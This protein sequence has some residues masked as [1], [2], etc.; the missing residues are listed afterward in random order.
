MTTEPTEFAAV[1]RAFD[2]A[3]TDRASFVSYRE[4]PAYAGG[5]EEA[6]DA[7]ERLLDDGRASEVVEMSEHSLAA[8]E[9]AIEAVDDSDGM[10][11]DL[12]RRLQTLHLRAC[13][14][15]QPDPEH[16]AERLFAWEMGSDWETFLGAAETYAE[17]LGARGLA[18]YRVLAE[19]AWRDVPE[20]RPGDGGLGFGRHGYFRISLCMEALA[21]QSG[22]LEQ[23]I[24]VMSR[25]LSSGW[26]F[27]RIAE[28]CREAG[29]DDLAASWVQRGLDAFTD[30]PD[31]R[32]LRLQGE[33]LADAG[34]HPQATAATWAA[35]AQQPA[36]QSFRELKK[37]AQAAGVWEAR[38]S[39]ALALLREPLDHV[40]EVLVVGERK[41]R[42]FAP[43]AS[44]LVRILLWDGDDDA[45]WAAAQQAGCTDD[46]WL[47]LARAR[48]Q[49]HP[50][51]AV[52]AYQRLVESAIERKDKRSYR[53]AVAFMKEAGTLMEEAG[54]SD[55]F[56]SYVEEVRDRHARK[57]S[58]I[59]L[60]DEM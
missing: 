58:L 44:E 43:D 41:R 17:V 16:L 6:V 21:R 56:P 20:Q 13:D 33:L 38:R 9:A 50:E 51:D 14:Q 36:M 53:D 29:R 45:A 8:I 18:C 5:I 34:R 42:R 47:R 31:V 4:M 49:Q 46:L 25:D 30:H 2:R 27:L 11:G 24:E 32:L 23:L 3:V 52:T 28:E 37:H 22:D 10:M 35:F 15:A 7:I 54:E 39:E 59:A 55:A 48:R 12:L 60:I 26:R 57:R 19:R 1:R 40:D